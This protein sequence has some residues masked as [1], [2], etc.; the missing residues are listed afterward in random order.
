MTACASPN[1]D[2]PLSPVARRGRFQ[3]QSLLHSLRP[4]AKPARKSLKRKLQRRAGK[5]LAQQRRLRGALVAVSRIWNKGCLRRGDRL[6]KCEERP[7]KRQRRWIHPNAWTCAGTIKLA[8]SSIGQVVPHN[9][10]QR[11]TRRELDAIAVVSLAATD[12]QQQQ[13]RRWEASVRVGSCS[14]E[15]IMVERAWDCT[16]LTV[17]YGSLAEVV[18]PHARYWRRPTK[19]GRWMLLSHREL[20]AAGL[21]KRKFSAGVLELM[22]QAG[23]LVWSR[24]E[25]GFLTERSAPLLFPP[26]YLP[27][28]SASNMWAAL[29]TAAPSLTGARLP[30]LCSQV[31]VVNLVL[32]AD[33]AG[34]CSRLKH[35]IAHA[36]QLHNKQALRS[37]AGVVVI[38]DVQCLGHVAHRIIEATFRSQRLIPR[39]HAVAWSCAQHA[40]QAVLQRAVEDIVGSDLERGYFPQCRPPAATLQRAA[41][42]VDL[43]LRHHTR[44]AARHE[45]ED[46]DDPT[47]REMARLLNGNW[48]HVCIEHYC[49]ERGCCGGHVREVAVARIVNVIMQGFLLS[50]GKD[51]PAANR[52]YTFSKHLARQTGAVLLH[53]VLPRA[54]ERAVELLGRQMV[55]ADDDQDDWRSMVAKRLRSAQEFMAD[56]PATAQLLSTALVIS[57]PLDRLSARVQHLDAHGMTMA[58]LCV[59]RGLLYQCQAHLWQLLNPWRAIPKRGEYVKALW[60]HLKLQGVNRNILVDGTRAAAVEIGCQVYARMTLRFLNWPWRLLGDEPNRYS[61]FCAE[62]RC[63]LDEWWSEPLRQVLRNPEDFTSPAMEQMLAALRRRVKGTNMGLERLLAEIK[64]AAP[65]VKRPPHMER[66]AYLGQLKMLLSLHL[67]LGREDP[68]GNPGRRVLLEEGLPIEAVRGWGPRTRAAEETMERNASAVAAE[69]AVEWTPGSESWPV[70]E[71]VLRGFLQTVVEGPR[72]GG[73]VAGKAQLLRRTAGSKMLVPD[74]KQIP[75]GTAFTRRLSCN[76]RHPGICCSRHRLFYEDALTFAASVERC[77]AQEFLHRFLVF[78]EPSCEDPEAAAVPPDPFVAPEAAAVQPP[79]APEEA[80]VPPHPVAPVRARGLQPGP[81]PLR[82]LVRPDRPHPRARGSTNRIGSSR[83]IVWHR[84]HR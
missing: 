26:C 31:R 61:A 38:I 4:L 2:K 5:E 83:G 46:E 58:E 84:C 41:V 78:Y 6:Q 77:L 74:Q 36:C 28:S 8:F 1:A 35:G 42:L 52:W 76:E 18:A 22:A 62:A 20:Q 66:V 12:F 13:T 40:F 50:L 19:G 53:R 37:E 47:T 32:P 68:R 10:A 81:L 63:C 39:L 17:S 54:L 75:Q 43:T 11:T 51:L 65:R 7:K 55:S 44:I 69:A 34:S 27:R 72:S 24:L 45:D 30:G 49:Y 25:S 67:S 70:A 33:L 3:P 80:A 23:N 60:F 82:P 16:P 21:L 57:E 73:G 9:Q 48:S 79:P 56:Q 14:T 29:D 15:W 59:E 64:S 71:E